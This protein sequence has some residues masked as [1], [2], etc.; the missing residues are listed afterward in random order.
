MTW[1]FVHLMDIHCFMTWRRVK[2]LCARRE[3]AR[4]CVRAWRLWNATLCQ[5]AVVQQYISLCISLLLFFFLYC[6]KRFTSHL[7]AHLELDFLLLFFSALN[8]FNVHWFNFIWNLLLQTLLDICFISLLHFYASN[9]L[10]SWSIVV[11]FVFTRVLITAFS[12]SLEVIQSEKMLE[13]NACADKANKNKKTTTKNNNNKIDSICICLIWHLPF[14]L[15][16]MIL[17][18]WHFWHFG[19]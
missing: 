9:C 13:N 18:C 12:A 4:V 17:R 16:N 8:L 5:F 1:P 7:G 3:R 15:V 10:Y 14:R 11:M 6:F 2:P 19:R